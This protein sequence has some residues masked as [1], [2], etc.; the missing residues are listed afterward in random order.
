MGSSEQRRFCAFQDFKAPCHRLSQFGLPRRTRC[1]SA[2]SVPSLSEAFQK[3][4][5]PASQDT[6]QGKATS[7]SDRRGAGRGR[8]GSRRARRQ[9][10]AFSPALHLCLK[11]KVSTKGN[12]SKSL[13]KASD[14]KAGSLCKSVKRLRKLSGLLADSGSLLYGIPDS[15]AGYNDRPASTKCSTGKG[16]G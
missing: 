10:Q 9:R 13:I 4:Y 1:Q 15:L 16:R 5:D 7:G 14:K 8:G 12:F 3:P 2:Q 11:G 6:Q